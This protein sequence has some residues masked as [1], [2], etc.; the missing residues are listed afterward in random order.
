MNQQEK[1]LQYAND[2]WAIFPT[3]G[4]IPLKGSGGFKDATQDQGKITEW[5]K[6]G[7]HDIGLATG[8]AN[9]LTVIDIDNS[10]GKASE[11]LALWPPTFTVA[12]P[13]GGYHLY[14]QYDET[15][16]QTVKF[17][18]ERQTDTRT[19]G[20]YVVAAGSAGY[21]HISGDAILPFP[22]ETYS[23]L[24]VSVKTEKPALEADGTVIEG[25]RN[26]Y[27][28]QVAGR[29]QR[30]GL[31]YETLLAALHA[32]NEARLSPPL[33]EHE[34]MTI[35]RSVF[36]YDPEAPI[37]IKGPSFV[38]INQDMMSSMLDYLSNKFAMS[39]ESTGLEGLD[40]MLGGGL[41]NGELTVLN[42]PAKTGKS[43]LIHHIIYNLLQRGVSVG[44]ASREMSP[45]TEVMPNLLSLYL[46]RNVWV[47]SP[48]SEEI[49]ELYSWPLY[50][51]SGYGTLIES[52]LERFV[53]DLQEHNVEYFFIDHLHWLLENPEDFQEVSK[54]IKSIKKWTKEKNVH[55]FLVVQP[56]KL[57]DGQELG[58]N[59]LRGGA[60][61]GQALDNLL[62]L[63][64]VK[65]EK[66]ISK[67]ALPVARHK[68]AEPGEIFLSYDK[69]TMEFTEAEYVE[70]PAET[71]QW[72]QIKDRF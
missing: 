10:D 44:Y 3:Q 51:S 42:A 70:A 16:P 49:G 64:R 37:E 41:R 60:S 17:D 55:I 57:M 4:K 20:G 59:T 24:A 31:A 15:I 13:S 34:V 56:P 66:N 47:E 40:R 72:P 9:N 22:R 5:W 26:N 21:E 25:G 50:F 14:Y 12:T 71:M 67:L 28:T 19:D 63:T 53:T 36:R 45:D 27:L 68:M 29:L 38:T 48:K 54:I 2:G 61:L 58:I 65:N 23:K 46:K 32:E 11:R 35:A 30:A 43:T 33:P 52:E 69:N 8:R 39:G 62:T 7:A 18:K 6:D 1:A